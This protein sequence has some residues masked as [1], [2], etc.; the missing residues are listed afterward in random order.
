MT[1]SRTLNILQKQLD[2]KK[3]TRAKKEPKESD[4]YAVESKGIRIKPTI[5]KG[6]LTFKR[7][8][9]QKLDDN[10]RHAWGL[11]LNVMQLI[12]AI[13]EGTLG[14]QFGAALNKYANKYKAESLV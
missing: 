10:G 6:K 11:T 1:S 9:V 8:Y 7:V 2:A 5:V 12:E 3:S 13:D 14:E 4:E